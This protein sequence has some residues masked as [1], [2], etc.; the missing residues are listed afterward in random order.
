MYVYFYQANK[1]IFVQ[2][3][4]YMTVNCQDNFL[5]VH[6][7]HI[8]FSMLNMFISVQVSTFKTIGKF[9]YR[10]NFPPS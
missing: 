2:E 10:T 8:L 4:D 3:N 7:C 1:K 5:I 9:M 6:Y